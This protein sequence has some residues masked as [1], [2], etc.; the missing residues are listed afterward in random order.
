MPGLNPSNIIAAEPITLGQARLHLKLDAT[1]S[2]ASHP[3]DALVTALIATCRESAE[4]YTGLA[5][6]N[7]S[8]TLT[9]DAFPDGAIDLQISKVNSI[10]SITYID[11]TGATQT[12][13]STK[14]TLDNVEKPSVVNLNY[15]EKWPDTRL[16]PNAVTVTFNAGYT[17]N[18]SPN[19]NS[20]PKSINQAM[21]LFIGH[22]YAN[23]EA[24]NIGSNANEIPLGTMHLLAQHRIN[25]G[26]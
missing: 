3:D 7:Q 15:N 9:L 6:A 20:I 5:I 22:L 21:L 12:L 1:G 25:I 8:Y 11:S 4:K 10:T 17:D 23:R 13:S 26:L 16:Q 14:Y 24:V 19:T 2:P 18:V